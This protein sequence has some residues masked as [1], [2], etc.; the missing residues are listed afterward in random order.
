MAQ[1]ASVSATEIE[2]EERVDLAPLSSLINAA[3]YSPAP[4]PQSVFTDGRLLAL[5]EAYS[6]FSQC[7]LAENVTCRECEEPHTAA[8]FLDHGRFFYRCLFNGRID[9][10]EEDLRLFAFDRDALLNALAAAANLPTRR[11]N[12]HSDRRL[13]RLGFAND[14][15]RNWIIGYA[16][17]LDVTNSLAGVTEAL[18][19][20]FSDGPGLIV[21]PSPIN[22]NLPLPRSYRL[23]ALHELF[24]GEANRIVLDWT[25]AW[26]RLGRRKRVPGIPG[27]PTELE[28]TSRLRRELQS[29]GTWPSERSAQAKLV[30][31]QWS[32]DDMPKPACKTIQNHLRVLEGGERTSKSP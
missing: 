28:K 20:Q 24:F 23:I 14:E 22:L 12:F 9:L 2:I 7:G 5:C 6:I 19:K 30:L 1:K 26:S 8:V 15:E 29:A 25:A 17:S 3:L 10:K 4:T 27:R 31:Q 11:I 21:T 16:D 13:V 32:N 18:E